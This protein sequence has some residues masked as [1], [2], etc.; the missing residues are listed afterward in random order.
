MRISAGCRRQIYLN[1]AIRRSITRLCTPGSFRLSCFSSTPR[2]SIDNCFSSLTET[3]VSESSLVSS[4]VLEDT[5]SLS[6]EPPTLGP[7]CSVVKSGDVENSCKSWYVD[8]TA[9]KTVCGGGLT[10]T[11]VNLHR[12]ARKAEEYAPH[13]DELAPE[14]LEFALRWY[15]SSPPS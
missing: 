12:L 2:E 4:M 13:D 10:P 9:Y 1:T 14:F 8:L 3:A 6:R 15:V 7:S 5:S 11:F